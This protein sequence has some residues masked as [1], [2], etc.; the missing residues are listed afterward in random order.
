MATYAIGDIQGCY[1]ELMSLLNK[2]NF[3]ASTDQLWLVGDLVNRGPRSIEVLELI[4]E[5]EP[6]VKCVLGNHDLH[7]IACAI[8]ARSPSTSDTLD[9]LLKHRKLDS[10]INWL[11]R[12]PLLHYDPDLN[13]CMVHAGIPHIWSFE[14]AQT[15]AVEAQSAI[16]HY[17]GEGFRQLFSNSADLWDDE[18][19]DAPRIATIINYFTRMRF[20]SSTG[21]LDLKSKNSASN[22]NANSGHNAWFSFKR[23]HNDLPPTLFGHWAALQGY[24][25]PPAYFGLDT[26]C[27]WGGTLTAYCIDTQTYYHQPSLK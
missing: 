13:V 1:N 3:S 12:Q 16:T 15:L 11:R 6:A 2:I 8:G 10:Y 27:V 9:P 24:F 17:S 20:V 18:L 19:A 26:G 25:Q 14:Q 5:I 23:T 21:Q 22:D 4:T 7:L